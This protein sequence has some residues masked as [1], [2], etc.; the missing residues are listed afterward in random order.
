MSNTTSTLLNI[1]FEAHPIRYSLDPNGSPLFVSKDVCHC[2]QLK[3]ERDAYR[4]LD[5]AQRGRVSKPTPGGTQKLR[6]VTQSG[7][8]TLT[9]KSRKPAAKRFQAWIIDEVLPQIIRY[10]SYIPGATPADRCRALHRRW[11]T[12]R[13]A[14]AEQG[15]KSLAQSGLLTIGQFMKM[16][17][18]PARDALAFSNLVRK[19]ARANGETPPRHFHNGHMT[20]A[21]TQ[22]TL[23]NAAQHHQ[24]TLNL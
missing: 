4:S 1:L 21:W 16:E 3:S 17:N 2:L 10:G 24:P 13:A 9:L 18:L 6:A 22:T 14:A 11:K 5:P 15:E 12:E 19:H 8:L 7:L 20:P 23:Q